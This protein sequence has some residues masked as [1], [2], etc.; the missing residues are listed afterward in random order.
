VRNFDLLGWFHQKCIN[1][2][3]SHGLSPLSVLLYAFKL[4][5]RNLEQ[6]GF[7]LGFNFLARLSCLNKRTVLPLSHLH[8]PA[9]ARLNHCDFFKQDFFLVILLNNLKRL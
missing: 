6:M 9:L 7:A 8:R 3:L 1:F 2:R 5:F 4:L